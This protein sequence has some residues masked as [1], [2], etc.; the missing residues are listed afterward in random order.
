MQNMIDDDNLKE[1]QETQELQDTGDIQETQPDMA[2]RGRSASKTLMK[3]AAILAVAGIVSKV[4]GAV[5]RIP[6][7][8]MIGAEGQSYYSAAYPVYQLFTV[9]ATAGF[10]VAISRMVSERIAK[11]DYINAHKAYK[12]ALKVS[13]VLG[14]VSFAIMFIGAGAIARFYKNP[15]AEASMRAV[16]FALLFLPFLASLRGYY[17]GR[18]EMR[19]TALTEVVE[20]MA[21]VSVGLSLAF[22]FYKT[23]LENAAAGATFGA[24]AGAIVALLVMTIIYRSDRGRRKEL[25]KQSALKKETDKERLRELLIFVV[26]ITI[27][28]SIMPIMFN[29]DAAIVMRRLLATGWSYAQAKTLYGLMGGYADP[30]VGM[31]FVF[32]DAICISMMPAV[33]TAFTL[34]NKTELDNHIRT[35]LKTMMIITYPCAVGLIVLA[36]PILSMLY[37]RKLDEAAMAVPTLQILAVSIV[38]LAIMRAFSTSL[39]GIGKMMLPVW[40]LFLGAVMKTITS[41]VLVG[42]PALN[43]KGAAIGSVIAY[44]T[45]GLLNWM[46]LRKYAGVSLDVKGVFITPLTASVIMGIGAFASYKLIFMITSSNALSTLLSILIAVVIYFVA[47]FKIRVI[48][49]EEIELIPKGDLIYR[50]AVRMKIAG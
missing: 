37:P 10:P 24:S 29:I 33:T 19:P 28:S 50:I 11:G 35:G 22:V 48:T 45:A 46:A 44:V 8:N 36:N 38:T 21:R 3:G 42:I 39:Q 4:F 23:S 40:N 20:Q 31:P 6:L 9:I 27:G 34:K 25:V 2:V 1:A 26:P 16:S 41:Y 47:V 30:I 7:T 43:I 32:V 15:G 12:L 17:Q 5:F 14:I 13:A 49:K 18:Q